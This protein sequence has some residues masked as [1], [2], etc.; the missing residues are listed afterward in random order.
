MTT[1]APSTVGNIVQKLGT[2]KNSTTLVVEIDE[3]FVQ[4]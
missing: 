4:L 2:A 1:T 3:D